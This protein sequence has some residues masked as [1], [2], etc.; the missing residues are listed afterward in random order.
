MERISMTELKQVVSDAGSHWFDPDALR[1]FGAKLPDYALRDRDGRVWFWAS[2]RPPYGP[3]RYDVHYWAPYWPADI[4]TATQYPYS[5]RAAAAREAER[6]ASLAPD[7]SIP[8]PPP[9]APAWGQFVQLIAD[10]LV[11]SRD[12]ERVRELWL[13]AD[14]AF[15]PYAPGERLLRPYARRLMRWPGFPPGLEPPKDRNDCTLALVI[16]AQ[17]VH[18][19]RLD[20]LSARYVAE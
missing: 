6:L 19:H 8:F 20:I 14:G 16:A 1:F 3:R 9:P 7:D 18:D 4:Q 13:L 15:Q 5:T 11:L 17:W 2:S 12:D 10:E